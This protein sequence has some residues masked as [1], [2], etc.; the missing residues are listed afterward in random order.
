[1]LMQPAWGAQ[2]DVPRMH[3]LMSMSQRGPSYLQFIS[4]AWIGHICMLFRA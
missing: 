4:Q 2:P 3:S 1:M